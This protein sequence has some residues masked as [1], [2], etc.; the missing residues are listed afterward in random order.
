MQHCARGARG[1]LLNE[2]CATLVGEPV[3]VVDD[4]G[5]VDAVW[6]LYDGRDVRGAQY[7][8]RPAVDFLVLLVGGAQP[9]LH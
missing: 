3:V 7:K 8:V 2:A 5:V 9:Q 4:H 1:V 6:T